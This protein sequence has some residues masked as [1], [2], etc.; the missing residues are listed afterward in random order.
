MSRLCRFN[1]AVLRTL[2]QLQ[3]GLSTWTEAN[4]ASFHSGP[5]IQREAKEDDPKKLKKR[6][7]RPKP[8]DKP[9]QKYTPSGVRKMAFF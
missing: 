8:N 4:Q 7:K 9:P 6:F 5:W 1:S 2:F 3:E